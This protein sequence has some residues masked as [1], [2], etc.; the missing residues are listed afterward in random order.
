MIKNGEY[1]AKSMGVSL[2]DL[3]RAWGRFQIKKEEVTPSVN[4]AVTKVLL[5]SKEIDFLLYL[6]LESITESIQQVINK[7]N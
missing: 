1:L 4:I 2:N 3:Q 6:G 7:R 5:S